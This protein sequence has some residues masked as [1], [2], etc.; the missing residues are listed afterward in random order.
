[1]DAAAIVGCTPNAFA[2]RLHR[3]RKRLAAR[4]EALAAHPAS[5]TRRQ[6]RQ[7]A[8]DARP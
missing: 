7:G 4:Y 8:P 6:R 5:P 2:I 1:V 3:A